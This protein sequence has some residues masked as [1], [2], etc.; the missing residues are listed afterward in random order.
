LAQGVRGSDGIFG[1]G[2]RWVV[3]SPRSGRCSLPCVRA[4]LRGRAVG[5]EPGGAALPPFSRFVD[6]AAS[7]GLT[8]VMSYGE[9]TKATYLTEIMGGGCAF[10]DYDNDGWMDVFILGGRTL[11]G[12]P[13]APATACTKT[14]ATEHLLM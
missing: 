14:I 6:V 9:G 4:I 12:I 5:L 8:K 2:F 10:I 13:P 7:A 11:E 1:Q 3:A